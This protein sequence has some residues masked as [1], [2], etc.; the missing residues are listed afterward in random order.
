MVMTRTIN[1]N[2]KGPKM[3]T[4]SQPKAGDFCELENDTCPVHDH[5]E[6]KREYTFGMQDATVETYGCGCACVVTELS[7]MDGGGYWY[8]DYASA[9]GCARLQSAINAAQ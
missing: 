4:A 9:A 8:P 1:Q 3:P 7:S 6:L 5:G 2:A